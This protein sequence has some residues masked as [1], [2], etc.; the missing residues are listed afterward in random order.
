MNTFSEKLKKLEEISNKLESQD[1]E[2]EKAMQLYSDGIALIK[3][4]EEFLN[5]A[6]LKVTENDK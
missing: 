1:I 4:C 6:Q 2:L 5:D 3:E